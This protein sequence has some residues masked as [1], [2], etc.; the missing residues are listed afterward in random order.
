MR[1]DELRLGCLFLPLP[2]GPSEIRTTSRFPQEQLKNRARSHSICAF[3]SAHVFFIGGACQNTQMTTYNRR[4]HY[5]R[6]KNGQL[7]WVSSHTVTRTSGQT[8]SSTLYSSPSYAQP[9]TSFSMP[10]TRMVRLPRSTGLVRPNAVCPVCGAHVYFYSNEYGSRVFFD[11]VG[12]PWPKHPCTDNYASNTSPGPTSSGRNAPALYPAKIGR[13]K[14][15]SERVPESVRSK[16]FSVVHV[17]HSG[18]CTVLGLQPIYQ[19]ASPKEWITARQIFVAVGQ[20]V[21]V[22]NGSMS[23]MDEGLGEVVSVAIQREAD[24]TSRAPLQAPSKVVEQLMGSY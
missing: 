1:Q 18:D 16:A 20:L 7:V 14:L 5:R 23:Y 4:G 17:R 8:Y 11:E 3:F 2:L 19:N 13:Q 6:G 15:Y 24:N 10:V 21:F 22:D 9:A 12:P